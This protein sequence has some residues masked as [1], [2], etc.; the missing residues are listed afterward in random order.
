ME[1]IIVVEKHLNA[2]VAGDVVVGL[3]VGEMEMPGKLIDERNEE[4]YFVNVFLAHSYRVYWICCS[5]YF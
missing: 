3:F 1:Y 4:A 2:S 5:F